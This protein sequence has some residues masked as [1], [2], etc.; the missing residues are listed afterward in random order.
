MH[1]VTA[2]A[3]LFNAIFL[4]IVTS[5]HHETC[6]CLAD[7]VRLNLQYQ[8]EQVDILISKAGAAYCAM[9]IIIIKHK[10]KATRFQLHG[11]T[12]NN[13]FYKEAQSVNV[14]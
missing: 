9:C 3:I 4:H 1:E 8:I 5:Y 14:P 10:H 11:S 12:Q 2:H 7:S 6:N 13:N